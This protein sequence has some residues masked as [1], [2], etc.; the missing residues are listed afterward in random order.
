MAYDTLASAPMP[1]APLVSNGSVQPGQK[2]SPCT[3]HEF[4][5]RVCG[6]VLSESISQSRCC[7]ESGRGETR[8]WWNRRA[9]PTREQNEDDRESEHR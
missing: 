9:R 4:G 8:G 3:R 6:L 5:R 2:L 7:L 1:A